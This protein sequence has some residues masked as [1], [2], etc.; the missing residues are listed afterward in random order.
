MPKRVIVLGALVLVAGLLAGSCGRAASDESTAAA[1]ARLIRPEAL[2]AHTAFLADDALEGRGT[3]SRGH[4]LAV[5][6]LRAQFEALGLRGGAEDG[7]F[8]QQVP[9]RRSEVQAEL[10]SLVFTGK[11]RSLSLVYGSDYGLQDTHASETCEYS[12]S[13]VFAGFGVTAEEFGY[14]D[15]AGL[16][17]DGQVVVIMREAPA[18]FPATLRAYYSDHEVKRRNASAH[19]AAGVIELRTPADE[20]R[21]PWQLLLDN[22]AISGRWLEADGQPHGLN[23]R[24]RF[25]ATMNRS[26]AEALFSGESHSLDEMFQAA[27]GQAKFPAFT[28]GKTVTVRSRS[29]HAPGESANVIALLEGAD[30]KLKN[31]YLVLSAHAD[32]LGIGPEIDGDNIY[33]GAWDNAVGCAALVEIARAFGASGARP[34]RSIL[35]VATT[36]EEAGFLGSEYFIRHPPVPAAGIVA[37]INVDGGGASLFPVKDVV[38]YGEDHTTLGPVARKAA[39]EAGLAVTPDPWPEEVLFVRQDAFPF[40]MRGV[41]ALYVDMGV[42]SLD[43]DVDGLARLKNWMVT[44]YHS[45][46]DDMGQTLDFES[47]A[48]FSRFVFRLCRAVANGEERP[49]WNEGDFFGRKFGFFANP[50]K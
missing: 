30:A 34:R 45:P 29:R 46:K 1:A 38:L 13:V 15:Y 2:R 41:P 4:D 26:G 16:N 33:N 18:S 28:L 10:A 14:D 50:A 12:G 17:A 7:D 8:F 43:P 35:F 31:E 36:G 37:N 20:K 5:K 49:K 22:W 21:V 24:I 39:A 42:T 27:A 19:G 6:Y 9:F 44:I 11:T 48:R 47:G 40:I 23:D 3:G 32:H 25:W